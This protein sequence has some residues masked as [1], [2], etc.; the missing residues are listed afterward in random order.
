MLDYRLSSSNVVI[1]SKEK[2]YHSHAPTISGLENKKRSEEVAEYNVDLA[3]QIESSYD[4]TVTISELVNRRG[5][6]NQT[7]NT[8]NKH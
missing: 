4:A 8:P 2:L 7:F 5:K 3:Q 1:K 6:L